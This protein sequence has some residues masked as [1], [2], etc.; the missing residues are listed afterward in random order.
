MLHGLSDMVTRFCEQVNEQPGFTKYGDLL[1]TRSTVIYTRMN[2]FRGVRG[3]F[4]DAFSVT[5]LY[6]V[7]LMLNKNGFGR[8]RVVA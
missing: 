5:R 8:K 3:L 2:L 4:Y 6:S 7:D 1:T